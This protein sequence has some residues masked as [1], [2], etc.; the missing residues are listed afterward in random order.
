MRPN[1]DEYF[2]NMARLIATRTTCSRRMVGAVLVDANDF[3]LST[4]YNGLPKGIEH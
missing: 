4:G 3:V 1:I 2:L